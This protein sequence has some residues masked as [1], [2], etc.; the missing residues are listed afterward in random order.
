M[1][2]ALL[3]VVAL[4]ATPAAVVDQ[5]ILGL[6]RCHFESATGSTASLTRSGLRDR[7]L[8]LMKTT[9]RNHRPLADP[10]AVVPALV[11]LDEDLRR[12]RTLSFSER[13]R[14]H[15]AI[16]GR[17]TDILPR[18]QRKQREFTRV[19]SRRRPTIP[20]KFLAGPADERAAG[21]R[22]AGEL[23]SLIQDTI[24]P[25]SWDVRSGKGTIRYY[26]NFHVLV[27]RNTAEVHRQIGGT[28]KQIKK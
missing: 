18:L 15:L 2:P 17:L 11:R 24:A 25:D 19:R 9:A 6:A 5:P 7:F 27:V 16:R 13:R 28:L 21:E 23:I 20:G 1:N 26:P 14:K 12:T 4:G 3:I 22:A 10:A 8:E